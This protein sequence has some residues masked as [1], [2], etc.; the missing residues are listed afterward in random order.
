[1]IA[2]YDCAVG[3]NVFFDIGIVAFDAQHLF[4]FVNE[5]LVEFKLFC[6]LAFVNFSFLFFEGLSIMYFAFSICFSISYLSF[7][8]LAAE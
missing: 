1:M 8:Y 7:R 6:P 5:L 3:Y 2:F 4:G